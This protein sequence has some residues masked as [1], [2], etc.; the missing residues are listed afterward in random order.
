MGHTNGSAKTHLFLLLTACILFIMTK[1][2]FVECIVTLCA[3]LQPS[4]CG[5]ISTEGMPVEG[6]VNHFLLLSVTGSGWPLHC[7]SSMAE[8]LFFLCVCRCVCAFP[9]AHIFFAMISSA[10]TKLSGHRRNMENRE[11]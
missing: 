4:C 8:F 6:L 7:R 1:T 9:H 2:N 3:Q 11:I 10:D 5:N